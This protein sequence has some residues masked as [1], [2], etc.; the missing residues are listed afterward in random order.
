MTYTHPVYTTQSGDTQQDLPRL[1]GQ[2][3]THYCGAYFSNGFHE[4]GLNSAIAVAD[5]F[6][7]SFP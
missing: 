5:D 4:D 1:N 6:G 2:H 3:R 7:V